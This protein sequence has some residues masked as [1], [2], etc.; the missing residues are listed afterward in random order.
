MDVD[1]MKNLDGH[2]CCKGEVL[3]CS[4]GSP[5]ALEVTSAPVGFVSPWNQ[6]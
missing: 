2:K 1:T 3:R 6:G 4:I 5:F